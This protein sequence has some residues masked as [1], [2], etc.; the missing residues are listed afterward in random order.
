MIINFIV[1]YGA[2]YIR[3]FTVYIYIVYIDGLVQD[4]SNSS[5]L[6]MELLQSCTNPLIYASPGLNDLTHYDL[7]T[8]YVVR[9]L[10]IDTVCVFLLCSYGQYIC[11]IIG[12]H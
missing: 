8:L 6:A 5:A 1:Y 11:S 7:V 9:S 10:N 3:D 12:L 4:C 2:S